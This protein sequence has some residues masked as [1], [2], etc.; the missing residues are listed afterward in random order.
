[1]KDI[2]DTMVQKIHYLYLYKQ[3]FQHLNQSPFWQDQLNLK[4][5]KAEHLVFSDSGYW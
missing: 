4:E 3:F 1:M 5:N 2:L